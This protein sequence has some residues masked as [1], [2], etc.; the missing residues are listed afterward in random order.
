[1]FVQD[2]GSPHP[3]HRY[4]S[5]RGFTLIELLV[6]I[7]IIAILIG[8]LV[9]AVQKVREAANRAAAT[10]TLSQLATAA[11]SYYGVHARF[12]DTF[13]A[14]VGLLPDPPLSPDGAT[15]GFQL[16]PKIIALHE[17][18][19]HAEPV[20]GVTGG[21]KLIL[22]VLPPPNAAQ[23]ASAPMPGAEAGRN[24]MFRNL[25]ALAAEDIAALRYLLTSADHAA[26]DGS[27]RPFL[28]EAPDRLDVM[29]GLQQFSR[30]GEFSL[31]SLFAAGQGPRS[32]RGAL[33]TRLF[34]LVDRSKAVLQ[35]GAYNEDIDIQVGDVNGVNLSDILSPG[36][37]G[38]A[39]IYNFG[40]LRALTLA[41]CPSDPNRAELLRWLDHAA[42]AAAR[43]H[44]DL[45]Q[46]FLDRYIA[47][48][49]KVSGLLLPAV[50]ADALIGIARTL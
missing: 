27:V 9:P 6:V 3:T 10:N 26:A 38:A 49:Q 39:P 50:Q 47:V 44:E 36:S 29:S 11:L 21:D 14:V 2:V 41:Y 12:P 32:E 33:Q 45:K 13:A 43:G 25:M 37:L 22:H 18:L 8:L 34:G 7:A 28:A 48:L 4:L 20:P 17:L 30:E 5:N 46:K 19:I 1:M 23:F 42:H 35:I 16:V 31:S 40:D 24:Q 15:S